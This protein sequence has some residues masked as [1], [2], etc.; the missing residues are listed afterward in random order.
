VGQGIW[1]HIEATYP[2]TISWRLGT[3]PW[4]IKNHHFYQKC[5]FVLVEEDPL[6]KPE[7]DSWIFRKEIRRSSKGDQ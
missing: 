7:D 2:E 3:P 5:G 1:A 6:I 4:A